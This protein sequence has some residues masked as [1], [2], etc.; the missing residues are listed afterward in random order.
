MAG[1][2]LF[3]LKILGLVILGL[4]ALV[5][6]GILLVLFVPVRYRLQ[7]S[8][9]DSPEGRLKI[10]WLCHLFSLS[11]S[12]KEQLSFRLRILGIP[13]HRRQKREGH[14]SQEEEAAKE[15]ESQV[16]EKELSY[17]TEEPVRP[18]AREQAVPEDI[19]NE[20]TGIIEKILDFFRRLKFS[21]LGFC[22]KLKHIK[23]LARTVLQWV[24]EE[25]NIRSLQFLLGQAKKLLA[26]V[27]PRKGQGSVTFGF[28]DPYTTGQI[29]TLASPFY[30]LYG[31]TIEL[32]PVFDQK[33]FS[34]QGSV[35][36]RIRLGYLL[37]LAFQVYRDKHTWNLLRGLR[38]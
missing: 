30:P 14:F 32:H 31:K 8:W 22:D 26:H 28:E 38:R 4:L 2:V 11:L 33:I 1:M 23:D 35:K 25:E 37:W 3:V 12:Y 16:Q 5:L 7:G 24:E 15:R 20:K 21:F 36:G 17:P 19:P 6:A 13:L 18:S 9:L 27:L 10:T 34:C 29:L